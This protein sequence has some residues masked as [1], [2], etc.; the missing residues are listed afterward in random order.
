MSTEQITTIAIKDFRKLTVY[1]KAMDLADKIYDIV[2]QIPEVEK[3]NTASQITRATT[4]ISA[5]IAEGNGQLFIK[6]SFT[7]FNNALGSANEVICWLEHAR[8]RGYI[9][10]EQEK[11]LCKDTEEII[12]MIMGYLRKLK[13]E[14]E[15]GTR[16]KAE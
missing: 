12:K 10:E 3:Y 2:E 5:N 11:A 15:Q 6:K 9:T 7:F 13:V 4:S 1:Q 14:M 8:R 16:S